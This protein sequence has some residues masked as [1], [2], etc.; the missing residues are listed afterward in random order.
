[1]PKIIRVINSPIIPIAGENFK[2]PIFFRRKDYPDVVFRSEESKLR[3]ITQEII[4][5]HII[6]RP[7]LVGIISAGS[8][9]SVF[10][11]RLSADAVRRLAQILL[12][13]DLYLEKQ[14]KLRWSKG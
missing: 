4:Q 1:M 13:R 8:T 10:L 9:L 5:F 7:Q 2:K 6:G 3:A 11:N 14:K 12:L